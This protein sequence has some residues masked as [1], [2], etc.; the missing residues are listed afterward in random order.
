MTTPLALAPHV[1]ATCRRLFES[2]K[3]L[4]DRAVAQCSD[5]E[6]HRVPAPDA[7]SIAVTMKHVAGN[8]RSR[9]TDFLESDGEKPWRDRDSEFED[10]MP[11]RSAL[12]AR[13]E[14]GWATLFSTL[15]GLRDEDLPR[16]VS[17]RGEPHT[18]V[19]ALLRQVSHYGYHVGQIVMGAR[20]LLGPRWQSLSIPRGG[21]RAH[22]AAMGYTPPS[23]A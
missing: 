23:T 13:W 19:E 15:A 6:L 14:E 3:R 4:A 7:N 5:E 8:L 18:V 11:V 1:L 22:D 21:S 20:L 9:W 17:I 12:L 2:Q 10:D 16:T